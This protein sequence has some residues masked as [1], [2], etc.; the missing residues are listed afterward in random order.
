[1]EYAM[2]LPPW[3]ARM[4][5]GSFG[6]VEFLTESHETKSGRRLAV[7]DLPGAEQPLVEDLGGKADSFQLNCYFIGADYDLFRDK[8]LLALNKPAAAWLMH[9]WRGALWVRAHNWSVHES[10]DKGGYC[11]V[12]V[13]FVPGG[14]VQA[15]LV[16]RTDVAL[17]KIKLFGDR[18]D[19]LPVTMPQLAMTRMI[20]L[21]QGQLDAVRNLLSITTLPLTWM[22]QARGALDG[23]RGE[24]GALL[25][26][27]AQYVAT[28]RSLANVLGAGDGSAVAD[29]AVPHFVNSLVLMVRLPVKLPALA[30]NS[31]AL[32]LNLQ[33]EAAV[34]SQL[35]LTAAAQMALTTYRVADDRDA[36][37]A[38]VVGAIDTL[39]PTMPDALFQAALDMRAALIDAL[40]AQD[41]KPAQVRDVVSPLPAVVLAHRLEVSEVVF[42]AAN[43]VRHP[44]FVQ[45]RVYG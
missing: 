19:Y 27:P 34:R 2:S 40:L 15:I 16:D 24:A 31:P 23:L 11:T 4:V 41:L 35:L 12:S 5:R 33:R 14:Q 36:A 45:G 32:Q 17:G 30:D 3:A 26:Q 6:E 39:L 8:F 18:V 28:M 25:A 37:L 20:A 29:T 42:L 7:H 1:M 13:E 44:L 43:K 10:N 9:P 21:V 22:N 38:S